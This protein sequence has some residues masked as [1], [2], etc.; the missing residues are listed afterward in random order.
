MRIVSTAE[1]RAIDR[2][3]SEK[4]GVPMST[5]MENAGTAVAKFAVREFPDANRVSVICGKGNNGGDG[6]VAA[7]KLHQ[8]GKQVQVM[9][10][11]DPGEIRGDAAEMLRRLPVAAVCVRSEDDL[12]DEP[13]QGVFEADFFVDAILGSGFHPPVTGLYAAAITRMNE[14]ATT[15][16]GS[17]RPH[18]LAVDVPSGVDSDDM[19]SSE[20]SGGGQLVARADAIIT[21]TAP[22]PAHVFQ[23]LTRGPIAVAPI[24]SP[25]EAINALSQSHLRVTTTED[26]KDLLQPR[27]ANSNKGDFGHVLIIGGSLGKAGA[28]SLAAI[29]ALRSG[30]GLVTVAVPKSVQATVA[31]FSPEIMTEALPETDAGSIAL[32]ALAYGRL[33]ELL[34]GKNV[35]AVGPGLSR[36]PET[37][38]FVRVLLEKLKL[39]KLAVVLDAD[40]L[41]AFE[42]QSNLL[43]GGDGE[44]VIT[45]HPGEMS[46][47]TGLKISQIQADRVGVAAKFA[48]AHNCTVVLKGD[49][50]VICFSPATMSKASGRIDVSQIGDIWINTTGNPGM[51]TGGTGDALTGLLAGL[52]AQKRELIPPYVAV[53]VRAAVYLHGLAGD[54]A[55]AALGEAGMLA[56]DLVQAIPQAFAQAAKLLRDDM[57]YLQ[58]P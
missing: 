15:A 55:A 13:A 57:V 8:A 51:A 17:E 42:N 38:E 37:A 12:A 31:G 41:N 45:P 39:M 58:R 36:N 46:R 7:R 9:L 3:T 30:A 32:S 33:D 50:T 25:V 28:P 6:L 18:I 47:L 14:A 54:C 24:G 4:Y 5:L 34:R 27:P 23:S 35:V 2:V 48:A 56:S 29:S 22:R 49:R 19:D 52:L 44:L 26:F 43:D 11:A 10:L 1:M 20:Q 40:G 16:A 53:A 21:F